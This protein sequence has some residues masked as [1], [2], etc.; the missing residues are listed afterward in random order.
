MPPQ[1]LTLKQRLA[2]LSLAPSSPTSPLASPSPSPNASAQFP[3]NTGKKGLFTP[4]WARRQNSYEPS[5]DRASRQDDIDRVR[6]VMS[7]V[8]FQAG[9]D[10]ECASVLFLL[11][12]LASLIYFPFPTM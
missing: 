1:T 2:A 3:R 12:T 9:V 7:R 11:I 6:D 4:P 5:G 10:Y 8:I